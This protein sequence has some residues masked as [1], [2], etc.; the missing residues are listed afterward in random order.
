MSATV[1]H[2]RGWLG[3]LDAVARE[4]DRGT[5]RADGLDRDDTDAS[6]SVSPS[7]GGPPPARDPGA[8]RMGAAAALSF[9]TFASFATAM[10]VAPFA[11][12]TFFVTSICLASVVCTATST[13]PSRSL[14]S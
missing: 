6:W 14:P 3:A 13:L 1:V 4:P 10:S 9:G 5:V 11:A 2:V 12:S 8:Q 7:T